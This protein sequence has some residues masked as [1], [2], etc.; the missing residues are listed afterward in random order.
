M[1]FCGSAAETWCPQTAERRICCWQ[2]LP[3]LDFNLDLFTLC[4]I[5]ICGSRRNSPLH[6]QSEENKMIGMKILQL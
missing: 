2:A 1:R 5:S 3:N 6:F 4:F